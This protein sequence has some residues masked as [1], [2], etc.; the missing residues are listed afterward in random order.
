LLYP[1]TEIIYNTDQYRE[2]SSDDNLPELQESSEG[3]PT[4]F[5]FL[6]EKMRYRHHLAELPE[7]NDLPAELS[8]GISVKRKKLNIYLPTLVAPVPPTDPISYTSELYGSVD[9][10]SL[11]MPKRP[12]HA[13]IVSTQLPSELAGPVMEHLPI[14][15]IA[16]ASGIEIG[17]KN[18]V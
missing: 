2:N 14:K 10:T 16:E 18:S 11:A 1:K 6:A 15:P 4:I 7:D 5:T 9:A 17:N 12:I 8:A 13:S 3:R